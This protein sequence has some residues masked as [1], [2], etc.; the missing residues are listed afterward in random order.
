MT[1]EK[2]WE[3]NEIRRLKQLLEEGKG[4]K[5]ISQI[6][7]K[8]LDSI[9]QKMFDLKLK[10]KRVEGGTTVFFFSKVACRAAKC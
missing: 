3:I 8:T 6:M 5:E 10:E 1:K 9:K 2:P 7:V 4:V